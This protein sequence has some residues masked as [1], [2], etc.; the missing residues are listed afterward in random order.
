MSGLSQADVKKTVYTVSRLPQTRARM[1]S[2][3]TAGL[4][5]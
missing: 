2:R 5:T 1:S 4:K 3:I